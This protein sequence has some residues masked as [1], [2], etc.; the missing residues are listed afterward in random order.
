MI[1]LNMASTLSE[2]CWLGDRLWDCVDI[3]GDEMVQVEGR[4]E[5]NGASVYNELSGRYIN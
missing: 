1:W 3:M 4:E 5:R 2:C